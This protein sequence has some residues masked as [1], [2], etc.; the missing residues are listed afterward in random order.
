M[1]LESETV[2][3]HFHAAGRD[4]KFCEIRKQHAAEDLQ[5]PLIRR[6]EVQPVVRVGLA[7]VQHRLD[8]RLEIGYHEFVPF[9][10]PRFDAIDGAIPVL[11]GYLCDV[12]FSDCRR[13]GLEIGPKAW[14][15]V[16]IDESPVFPRI[17]EIRPRP[18]GRTAD[19]VAGH[20]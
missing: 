10:K 2:A 4:E 20:Q 6:D 7:S 18:I 11:R 1:Y 16:E 9:Q 13:V 8:E 15:V 3:P 19:R 14:V 17:D 5:I 12:P